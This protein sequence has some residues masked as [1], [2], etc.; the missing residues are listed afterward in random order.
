MGDIGARY[1]P[2]IDSVICITV[3]N[4]ATREG[5]SDVLANHPIVTVGTYWQW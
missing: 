2:T 4:T 5:G 1:T 3:E